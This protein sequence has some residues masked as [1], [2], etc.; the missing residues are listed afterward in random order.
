MHNNQ[1]ENIQQNIVEILRESINVEVVKG[2]R[3]SRHIRVNYLSNRIQLNEQQFKYLST[4][5]QFSYRLKK[6]ENEDEFL[7]DFRILR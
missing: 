7:N 4:K 5:Y 6:N 1:N 3:S 2:L